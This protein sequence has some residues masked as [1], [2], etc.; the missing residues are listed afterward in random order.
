MTT[1]LEKILH[2]IVQAYLKT[3]TVDDIKLSARA[4]KAIK[5]RGLHT[6]DGVNLALEAGHF[7]AAGIEIDREIGDAIHHALTNIP[8]TSVHTAHVNVYLD[9]L[10]EEVR[11][12]AILE[13]DDAAQWADI[14]ADAY[15]AKR[16][17]EIARLRK[18]IVEFIG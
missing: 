4:R 18:K 15:T 16:R 17:A 13:Q 5:A 9:Q 7:E 8:A 3:L 12:L 2:E 10:V 1:E 11:A 6:L 14:D